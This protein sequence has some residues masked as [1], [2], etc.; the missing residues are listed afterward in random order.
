MP[1][2]L[3]KRISSNDYDKLVAAAIGSL[4]KKLEGM[5]KK[6]DSLKETTLSDLKDRVTKLETREKMRE[7]LVYAALGGAVTAIISMMTK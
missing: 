7:F 2:E 1:D 4:D 3:E 5:E 6:I